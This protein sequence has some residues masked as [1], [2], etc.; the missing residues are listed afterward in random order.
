M[1]FVKNNEG[2][3]NFNPPW[4]FDHFFEES[5]ISGHPKLSFW[6]VAVP[7]RDMMWYEIWRPLFLF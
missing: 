1:L 5:W 3:V 2:L 7:K 6:T 4:K